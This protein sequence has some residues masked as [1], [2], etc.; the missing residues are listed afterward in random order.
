MFDCSSPITNPE[1]VE[2]MRAMIKSSTPESQNQCLDLIRKA[3]FLSPATISPPPEKT[4]AY[5][6]YDP[7]SLPG[8]TKLYLHTIR[9]RQ[10]EQFLPV[11]TDWP[12]LEKW[13]NHH[14]LR[15][16]ISDWDELCRLVTDARS[17][18]NGF[19]INP[20]GENV[21]FA[22]RTLIRLLED[23]KQQEAKAPVPQEAEAAPPCE[24]ALDEVQPQE[25]EGEETS[26]EP[27]ESPSYADM[28]QAGEDSGVQDESF[29]PLEEISKQYP[30][31]M[32]NAVSTLLRRRKCISC[33]YLMR[34]VK[35]ETASYLIVVDSGG[36]ELGEFLDDIRVE[37]AS[38]LDEELPVQV[39]SSLSPLGEQAIR[40]M[41]PFYKKRKKFLGLF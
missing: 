6:Q 8:E 15:A 13:A 40:G 11:F 14:R 26:G 34:L 29:V 36:E 19:V 7:E 21:I 18:Y 24:E 2:S 9:N 10:R 33:A 17:P 12:E 1:L 4:G 27:E 39:T 25:P 16:V 35:G 32:A 5:D 38:A 28:A 3:H 30:T 20:M 23:L 22:K 31:R 41:T 37:A